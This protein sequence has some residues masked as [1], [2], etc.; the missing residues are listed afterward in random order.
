M[1]KVYKNGERIECG[2]CEYR[3]QR[4]GGF[5]CVAADCKMTLNNK[6]QLVRK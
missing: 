3:Q 5:R 2:I 1:A 4:N 6:G